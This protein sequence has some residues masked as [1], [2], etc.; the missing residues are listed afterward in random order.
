[1]TFTKIL[2][3]FS[4]VNKATITRQSI[5]D[6]LSVIRDPEIPVVSIYEIGLLRDV[7]IVDDRV[8]I[9]VTPTYNSCPAM[10]IIVQD[11][12]FILKENQIINFEIIV[13]YA[14]AWST[15]SLSDETLKKLKTF[16]I[17]P[18]VN[19]KH[20]SDDSFIKVHCPR[21]GTYETVLISQFGSTQLKA[22][23]KCNHCKEVF[24][25]FKSH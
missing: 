1:M 12:R 16:G 4:M 19:G 10:E 6:L 14:P 18:S 23:Y 8:N 9:H 21:C 20:C 11:I 22:L 24:D 17:T 3:G 2:P 5:L 7:S 13:D 25:S 15:D